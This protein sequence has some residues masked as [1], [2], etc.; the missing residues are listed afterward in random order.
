M[1]FS[2]FVK[3]GH[4]NSPW[5]TTLT[6]GYGNSL[7]TSEPV[8]NWKTL[9]SSLTIPLLGLDNNNFTFNLET[10]YHIKIVLNFVGFYWYDFKLKTGKK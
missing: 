2:S 6:Y 5:N 10:N 8:L 4:R 3:C 1:I 7:Y 9:L